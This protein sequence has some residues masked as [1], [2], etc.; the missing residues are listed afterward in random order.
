[1]ILNTFSY[2]DSR[3]EKLIGEN[4]FAAGTE[5]LF[6]LMTVGRTKK[7]KE[8]PLPLRYDLKSGPS[9]IKLIPTILGYLRI[10]FKTI[11]LT[12]Y[13]KKLTPYDGVNN[14]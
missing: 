13:Y 4:G 5:L 6:K 3:N 10:I 11:L 9:K 8:I 7:I 1:M 14:R 2:M 12:K